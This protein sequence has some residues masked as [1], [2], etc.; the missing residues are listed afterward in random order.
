MSRALFRIEKASQPSAVK[1]SN[2]IH[3]KVMTARTIWS[4]VCCAV[5]GGYKYVCVCVC[6][7]LRVPFLFCCVCLVLG[8]VS[9]ETQQHNHHFRGPPE[10]RHAQNAHQVVSFCEATSRLALPKGCEWCR[11]WAEDWD[12]P[13]R[14]SRDSTP[15]AGL[16]LAP[17][18][19]RLGLSFA[20]L[21]R[22]AWGL[23]GI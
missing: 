5:S 9:K 2:Q 19:S 12:P 17:L 1:P 3:W 8:V 6:L 10:E 21:A 4:N 11:A 20:R 14:G 23:E 15:R 7:V 18:A 16:V 22:A 13:A